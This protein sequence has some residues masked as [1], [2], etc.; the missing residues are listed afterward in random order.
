MV[1][2]AGFADVLTSPFSP[3]LVNVADGCIVLRDSFPEKPIVTEQVPHFDWELKSHSYNGTFCNVTQARPRGQKGPFLYA[4]KRLKPEWQYSSVGRAVM[5]RETELGRLVSHP[6]L[7]PTLDANADDD[8]SFLVQPW[9][10]GK[11]LQEL[12]SLGRTA[13]PAETIW[14]A[15]QIAEALAALEAHQFCHSDVKPGNIIVSPNG[16]ATLIDLGLARR[17]GEPS[18]LIDRAVCGTPRYMAPEAAEA[19]QAIDIRADLYS[20]GLVML[21]MMFGKTALV[22]R[23]SS[24]RVHAGQWHEWWRSPTNQ[25]EQ[26]HPGVAELEALLRSMTSVDKSKRPDSANILLRRLVS[27]E[28]AIIDY[29]IGA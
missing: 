13:K 12:M 27:I 19:S 21:E 20:L 8:E 23:E 28:I 15:R 11:T 7:V 17:T 14:I 26:I 16:H 5:N 2:V 22:S 29:V 3:S 6:H 25:G 18:L 24:T 1:P 4:M 9:L 10:Q